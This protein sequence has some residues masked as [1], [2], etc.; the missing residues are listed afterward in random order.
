MKWQ[1]CHKQAP[2]NTN[3]LVTDG[4][5][6]F[7]AFLDSMLEWR[8]LNQDICE[9]NGLEVSHWMEFPEPPEIDE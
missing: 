7:P 8:F 1:K 5:Y 6:V 9:E 3:V 2:I 4:E